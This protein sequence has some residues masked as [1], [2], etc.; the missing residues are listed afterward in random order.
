MQTRMTDAFWFSRRFGPMI[1]AAFGLFLVGKTLSVTGIWIHTVTSALVIYQITG[2]ASLVGL[3]TAA[4]FAPQVLTP[5]AGA[6]ADRGNR[7]LQL[8]SGRL[9]LISA[10]GGL[11]AWFLI[12]GE[13]GVS[14][15]AVLCSS[16]LVGIGFVIGGPAM[17]SIVPSLV[18]RDDL[19]RAISLDAIPNTLGQTVGP[20]LGAIFAST[21]G[22][23]WAYA[24]AAATHVTLA[25]TATVLPDSDYD[26][27][28][29]ERG[30]ATGNG[31]VREV[32]QL[33]SQRP[34]LGVLLLGVTAVGIGNDPVIT[35]GPALAEKLGMPT[36][37]AGYLLAYFGLGALVGVGVFR[38]AQR[39]ISLSHLIFIGL[40]AVTVSHCTTAWTNIA[41]VAAVSLVLGGVGIT[42]ALTGVTAQI[43]LA[44]EEHFRGRFMALYLV[45]LIGIRPIAATIN[46]AITDH[47]SISLALLTTAGVVAFCGVCC[48]IWRLES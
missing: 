44:I 27:G 15:A 13:S 7:R 32:L 48:L 23:A 17:L 10:S 21:A 19:K 22:P 36:G 41:H 33:I 39:Q 9:I 5:W 43:Q 45:C 16:L 47:G 3:H 46:G 1:N 24:A 2:S 25:I 8:L 14:V 26:R 4:Q 34:R 42:V 37:S 20:A 35:L 38:L 31:T 18:P 11:A 12:R 40:T 6:L 29:G 30:V 28:H